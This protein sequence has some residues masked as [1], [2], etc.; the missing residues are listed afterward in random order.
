MFDDALMTGGKKFFPLHDVERW[1]IANQ[2]ARRNIGPLDRVAKA[3]EEPRNRRCLILRQ[4]AELAPAR[5]DARRHCH[6]R[7]QR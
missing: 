6:E 3:S 5:R 1:M 7:P 2:L 4:V